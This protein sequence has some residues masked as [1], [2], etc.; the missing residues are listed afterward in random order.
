MAREFDLKKRTMTFAVGIG[1][2]CETLPNNYRGWHVQKQLFRA[3]T[4]AAANYRAAARRK[5]APDFIS[6]IGTAIEEA[7]ESDFWL[8]FSVAAGLTKADRVSALRKEA[9]ELVAIFYA[10][11][12]TARDKL[13]AE[14]AGPGK[15]F[16]YTV[17]D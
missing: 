13:K 7:D 10:S 4:G 16:W 2:F 6:K 3:G 15:E 8:E 11:R 12:E 1:D 14:Q 17:Q 5:S 9:D